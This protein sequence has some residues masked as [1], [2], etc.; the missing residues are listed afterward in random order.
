M[1]RSWRV[2]LKLLLATVILAVLLS[3]LYL[4]MG[5]LECEWAL[6]LLQLKGSTGRAGDAKALGGSLCGH[7]SCCGCTWPL[8]SRGH[9][10]GLG[11]QSCDVVWT[12]G[13]S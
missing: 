2:K 10:W 11:E 7:A 1:L 4:F 6:C 3:W 9:P 12:L 13:V 5:S 8:G